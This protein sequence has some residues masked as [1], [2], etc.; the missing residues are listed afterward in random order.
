MKNKSNPSQQPIGIFDSG[1][2]GLSVLGA[3]REL[4]PHEDILYMA[5]QAH[6]PYGPR[7]KAQIRDFS[8]G[9]TDFLLAD[10]AKLIVVACNT[11]SAAAL[12]AL[13]E[14]YPEVPFVGMEPA[15][16]PAAQVTKMGRVGVL[17]TQTTFAGDLYAALVDRF[18]RGIE[19]YQSTCPGLVEQIEQGAL[20]STVTR[21]ILEEALTPMLVEGVDTVVLGCTH[22]P[23]VIPVIQAITGPGVHTIDPA[24]AVAR[25][26]QHLLAEGGLLNQN[27]R[28]GG[29]QIYTSGEPGALKALLPRLL[30]E[31]APV[32]S[33]V[34]E[35][36]R[37]VKVT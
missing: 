3:V 19:I 35:D 15:I 6:I 11:A 34:W 1:V 8:F 21:G 37:L 10:G 13:R 30:G 36:D 26:T 20:D 18:A 5:D 16:K 31:S 24:P 17:A 22:Y 14:R 29:I 28:I 2:G 33:L 23:F 32:S 7:Q 25:Q 9:V 4:L 27:A 12:Y